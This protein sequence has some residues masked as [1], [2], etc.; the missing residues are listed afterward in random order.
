M[1][2]NGES[3]MNERIRELGFQAWEYAMNHDLVCGSVVH[4]GGVN[5]VFMDLYDKK[6]AE[7]IIKECARH[8]VKISDAAPEFERPNGYVCARSILKHFGVE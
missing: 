7:L 5:S 6:L 4:N 8:C 1:L 3:A 2:R